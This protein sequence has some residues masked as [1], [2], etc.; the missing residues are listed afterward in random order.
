MT[1]DP[2]REPPAG[3]PADDE[4]PEFIGTLFVVMVFIMLTAG[5]WAAVYFILLGR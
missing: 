2:R 3:P 1:D 5:M 4:E